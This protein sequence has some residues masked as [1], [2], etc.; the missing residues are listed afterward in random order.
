MIWLPTG[1]V[2]LFFCIW[3]SRSTVCNK[4]CWNISRRELWVLQ[5]VKSLHAL[6]LNIKH[7]DSYMLG[8]SSL[9]S[10]R[11]TYEWWFF[12]DLNRG[13]NVTIKRSIIIN[14][15][16]SWYKAHMYLIT[17]STCVCMCWNVCTPVHMFMHAYA[18][19]QV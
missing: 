18:W 12:E 4:H 10:W 14:Y 17:L 19:V 16:S 8:S 15:I 11:E 7:L 9:L 3:S 2:I 6:L 1:F 5:H 13:K